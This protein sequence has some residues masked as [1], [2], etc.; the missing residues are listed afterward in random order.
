MNI[1]AA[2]WANPV[3]HFWF[4]ELTAKDWFTASSELDQTITDRFLETH[5]SL[6]RQSAAQIIESEQT[7]V[8]GI[9]IFDQFSRNMFR[10]SSDAFAYDKRA[11]NLAKLAIKQQHHLNL[12][13]D[14][15]QFLYMPFMHSE[16]LDDQAQSVAFF[17]QLNK[18][19]HALEHQAIIEQF[20]RF[21]HRN[22]SLGRSSTAAEK[23]YLKDARRFGQ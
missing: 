16:Q 11:L 17:S 8:A 6:A 13:P 22:E 18:P 2:D 10:G 3:L 1:N 7:A 5:Q 19:E 20:G 12:N 14:E 23:E 21:P 15:Q 9:I 4:H